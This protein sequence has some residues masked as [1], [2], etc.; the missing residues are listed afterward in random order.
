MN[1]KCVMS[2]MCRLCGPVLVKSGL[3]FTGTCWIDHLDFNYHKKKV[4]HHEYLEKKKST[5]ADENLPVSDKDP[6]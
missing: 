2:Y 3:I 6:L 5:V 4:A 1:E